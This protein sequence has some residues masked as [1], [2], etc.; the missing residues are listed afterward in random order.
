MAAATSAS[1]LT[2]TD[3]DR[4]TV[5]GR[6]AGARD[7]VA[8]FGLVVLSLSALLALLPPQRPEVLP[9][10]LLLA[11][12][13]WGAYRSDRV[14][15]VWPLLVL[16]AV[17]L[18]A[19][20]TGH[21]QSP[22]LPALLCAGLMLG[23][24]ADVPRLG[25]ACGVSLL[26]FALETAPIFTST[27]DRALFVAGAQWTTLTL[28]VGLV[29]RWARRLAVP[30]LPSDPYQQARDLLRELRDQSGELPGGLDASGTAAALLERCA[31]VCP[32]DRS[33]VVVSL[34]PGTTTPLAVRGVDRVPWRDDLE[35]IVPL[36][37]AWRSGK[38]EQDTR[39]T[40][41]EGRRRGST[42]LA[43]PLPSAEGSF[44]V[45]VLEAFG[46]PAFS[47][48]TVAAVERL[49]TEASAQLE[50]SMLLEEVRLATSTGER[51]RLA[52]EMHDGIGQELAFVGYRLDEL[53]AR[54]ATSPDLAG[55]AGEIRQEVTR[56]I[57]DLR[58]SITTM[59]TTVR[60]DLGLGQAL[61]SYLQAVCSGKPI[62]LSLT[63]QESP[64]RLPADQ[65]V[66]L[67]AAAQLFAAQVRRNP[68][69][70]ALKVQLHVDS[71][72]ALLRMESDA[73]ISV[74][75]PDVAFAGLT[76]VGAVVSLEQGDSGAVV[77]KVS[78][79]RRGHGD[80]GAAG[81]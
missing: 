14:A 57:G 65:E 3:T 15:A 33:A 22:L 29:A 8:L 1:R 4:V 71:P 38:A 18:A 5:A 78:M 2:R 19:P 44:G 79:G 45:I 27:T 74:G 46:K 51:N 54:A 68:T 10:V 24:D 9:L 23:L 58:L 60:P 59:R 35:E 42:L 81:R 69:V 6:Q 50:S 32:N 52:R 49:A 72:S 73:Q 56:L 76:R 53:K 31:A 12:T 34:T 28:A 20:W 16:L 48:E 40:D 11:V 26:V 39:R 64:Y 37:E 25:A 13:G 7:L 43:V 17:P 70:S 55:L 66:A 47:E 21:E 36:R 80:D 61:S 75:D 41:I 62:V 67:L 63:L 77:L 30:V